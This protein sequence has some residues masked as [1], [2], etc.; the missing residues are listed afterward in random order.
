MSHAGPAERFHA[1]AANCLR[2]RRHVHRPCCFPFEFRLR[3][4]TVNRAQDVTSE[5]DVSGLLDLSVPP[6]LSCTWVYATPVCRYGADQPGALGQSARTYS[7]LIS[8]SLCF[9]LLGAYCSDYTYLKDL[10]PDSTYHATT[11]M[12]FHPLHLSRLVLDPAGTNMD[13]TP[14]SNGSQMKEVFS[15]DW[16]HQSKLSLSL[17]PVGGS[18]RD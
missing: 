5:A 11:K 14:G 6:L 17:V 15:P 8:R 13:I 1:K 12:V 16:S 2:H 3:I 7:D 18:N 10:K 9:V 4:S